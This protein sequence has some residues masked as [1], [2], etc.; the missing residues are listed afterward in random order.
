MIGSVDAVA[1]RPASSRMSGGAVAADVVDAQVEQVRAVAGLARGRSRRSAGSRRRASRRGTPW[2][3]WRWSAPPPSA[4]RRPARTARGGRSTTTPGVALRRRAAAGAAPRDAPR[5]PPRCARAS[6]RSSRRPA[7]APYSVTN[8]SQRLGQLVRRAAGSTAPV[9]GQLRQAGVRHH[10]QRHPGVLR[11]VAQVLGHLGRAG[12]AVEPDQVDAE[13]LERGQRRADLAAE[14]HRAGGLDGDVADQRH[15]PARPRPSP[16]ATPTTAALVCSRSWQVSTISASA[17]PASRPAAFSLVRVAQRRRTWR[18]RASAASCPGRSS[19][20]RTGAAR[21]S[22]T[23][24][25][26]SRASRAPASDS[27]KIRSAMPYSPR[28]PRLAPNV[29]VSTQ[30]APA[31]RYASWMPRHDVGPGDV[32]DLVAALVTLEVVE[33]G[34]GRLQ[35]RAHRAVGDRGSGRPGRQ[36]ERLGSH[37]P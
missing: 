27:S 13:R 16:G 7:R 21:R 30:S 18:G 1:N 36:G 33:G 23:A 5:R 17:P 28:L 8:R 34:V 32:E 22:R 2:S 10:R 19:R 31:A 4:R 9:G 15:R 12:G 26:A 37:A 35:H 6:C 11:Q 20:A 3:R 24:S 29:L 25:A 14:Q